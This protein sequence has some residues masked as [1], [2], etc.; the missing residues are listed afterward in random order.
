MHTVAC[1]IFCLFDELL[2]WVMVFGI[3]VML[4]DFFSASGELVNDANNHELPI[5]ESALPCM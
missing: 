4:F 5:F 1:E 2:L 3:C